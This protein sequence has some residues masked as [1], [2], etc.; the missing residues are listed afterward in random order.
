M[1][2]RIKEFFT[3]HSLKLLS[4]VCG[5]L[6]WFG[7]V[8]RD[9]ARTEI[10]LP[11]RI[12][13]LQDNMALNHPLPETAVALLEGK[14]INLI[15]LKFNR[16]A[17]LEVDLKNMPLGLSRISSERVKLVS[18]SI[19]DLIMLRTRQNLNVDLDSRI[20]QKVPIQSRITV[21][22]VPGFTLLGEPK[23]MPD[24]V[25]IS[26]ARGAVAKIKSVPTKE[27][28]ITNLKWSNS[29]PVK[30][31]LTYLNSIVDI[32]DTA[33]FVQ[34]KIEPLE[35][36]IFYGIPVNLIG[37]YD[38][39]TYSLSPSVADVEVSGGKDLISNISPE[40]INL[41]IEF[42]RFSIENSAELNPT[43]HI[44]Y[45]VT[46]WQILPDKFRLNEK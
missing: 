13:N 5:C 10:E 14:G 45:P 25:I 33:V 36:K 41:Y 11:I 16:N 31:D 17:R 28:L 46:N 2:E 35:H 4:L 38:R 40:D 18:P 34:F 19:P 24:S 42:S 30:L 32:A 44:P 20:D 43:V 8:S 6:I 29:L 21:Q 12:V 27:E 9:E 26:G 37:N 39:E 7:V 22:A 1:F 15:H 23:I 3:R